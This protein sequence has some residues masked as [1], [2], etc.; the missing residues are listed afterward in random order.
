MDIRR[1]TQI[2]FLGS[3]RSFQT[4]SF[5]GRIW[6]LVSWVGILETRKHVATF[7]PR[8]GVSRG[9]AQE[10]SRIDIWLPVKKGGKIRESCFSFGNC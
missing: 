1:K 6:T 3:W 8:N 9:V 10:S 2:F 5:D 7:G 4:F